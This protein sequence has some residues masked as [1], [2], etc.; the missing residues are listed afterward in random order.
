MRKF[1]L[2]TGLY[3]KALLAGSLL[4]AAGLSSQAQSLTDGLKLHYTFESANGSE[5]PDVSGNGYDGLLMGATIGVTNGKP[6]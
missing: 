6:H 4:L 5:L 2:F 3:K 1:H